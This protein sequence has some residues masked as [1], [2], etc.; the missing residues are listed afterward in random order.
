MGALDLAYRVVRPALRRCDAER[1]HDIALRALRLAGVCIDHDVIPLPIDVAPAAGFDKNGIVPHGVLAA[2]GFTRATV[3][4]V[5]PDAWKGNA[6][7]RVQRVPEGIVNYL[8]LPNEGSRVLD[9]LESKLPVT[10]SIAPTPGTEGLG[11]LVA[12]VPGRVELN[13]SC[14][15]TGDGFSLQTYRAA[16]V[17][18]ELYV[19]LSPDMDR[20]GVAR[21]VDTIDP[22][23]WVTTNTTRQHMYGRGGLSGNGLYGH[24]LRTQAMLVNELERH[25]RTSRI[26]ACGGIDSAER[27]LERVSISTSNVPVTEVQI[28]TGL[29]MHGP[30]LLTEVRAAA[31]RSGVPRSQG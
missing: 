12:R 1:A 6:R 19:K 21:L 4:T 20:E 31:R 10:V 29:V 15:N 30:R 13:I 26:V 7:P 16:R 9:R 11:D 8:G 18:P 23:G 24:A 17:A 14:P 27:F 2:L 3:G 25:G 28:Y 5:T 22:D